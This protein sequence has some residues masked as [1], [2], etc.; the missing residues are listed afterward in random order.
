VQ[1]LSAPDHQLRGALY[2]HEERLAFLTSQETNYSLV[3]ASGLIVVWR[4]AYQAHCCQPAYY[5]VAA[6]ADCYHCFVG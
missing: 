4:A 3:S 2:G 6:S 5:A 1:L